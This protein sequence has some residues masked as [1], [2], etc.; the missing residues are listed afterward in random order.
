MPRVP[1]GLDYPRR[2]VGDDL[3]LLGGLTPENL[4]D[5]LLPAPVL[6]HITRTRVDLESRII[7]LGDIEDGCSEWIAQALV[8]MNMR[9]TITPITLFLNTP[10]GSVLDMFAIHDLIRTNPASVCTYGYGWVASAGVLLLAAGK[11]RTVTESCVLMSHENRGGGDSDLRLSEAKDR[12]KWEDWNHQHWCDL[13]ARY[14]P[15]KDAAWWS[16]TTDRK[17]EYWLLGGDAIV[18]AGLA[19]VVDK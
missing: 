5:L 17:A 12:R 9:S 7:Y 2:N 6:S 11:R 4:D 3:D 10:G 13:M 19:D 15:G 8:R 14:T 16:R 18:A 1:F